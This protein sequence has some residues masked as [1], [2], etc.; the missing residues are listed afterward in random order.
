MARPERNNVDYFPFICSEGKKMFYLEETYGND[1]FAVFVKLLR[2]LARTDYHYLNLSDKTTLMFLSAKC[3]VSIAVLEAI[4]NDLVLLNKFD[5]FLWSESRVIWCQ[6]F[7]DNIQD[8]YKK[9]NNKCITY[10]GLRVLLTSLGI[11]KQSKRESKAPV[12]PH[13]KEE[14]SK[15]EYSKEDFIE[16][17][18]KEFYSSLTIFTTEFSPE[19][20]RE[21]YDYWSE[22]NKSKTKIKFQLE[23]TWDAHKRILRWVKNDFNKTVKNAKTES[24]STSATDNDG[25]FKIHRSNGSK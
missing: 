2:E 4:I 9:R 7:V 25:G 23:K 14:Y 19:T 21:F 8:A 24:T 1:G 22:P 6:D 5:S 20:I 15:E 3:K 10:D 12:N 17:I 13:S 11:L 18:Q 16:K